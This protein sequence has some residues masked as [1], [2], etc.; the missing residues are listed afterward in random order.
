M[1][2][3]LKETEELVIQAK[4]Y[5]QLLKQRDIMMRKAITE[6]QASMDLFKQALKG[7][8]PD[9]PSVLYLAT[10]TAKL[11]Q[12]AEDLVQ[13]CRMLRSTCNN[14]MA[15]VSANYAILEAQHA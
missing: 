7:Y 13:S 1:N 9:H 11:A 14:L 2:Q 15:K 5:N 3:I 10:E 4:E 12:K 8:G 6:M